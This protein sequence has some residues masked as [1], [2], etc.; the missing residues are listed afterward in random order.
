MIPQH[1]IEMLKDAAKDDFK[2]LF[3]YDYRESS[4]EDR[5][6]LRHLD[7]RFVIKQEQFKDS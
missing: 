1:I 6:N 5:S 7:C 2:S 3:H 4:G